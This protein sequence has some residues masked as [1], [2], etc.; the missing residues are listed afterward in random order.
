MFDAITGNAANVLQDCGRQDGLHPGN[1]VD[2]NGAAGPVAVGHCER[3]F[4]KGR[5]CHIVED[6][7][8]W[9]DREMFR[10]RHVASGRGHYRNTL[11]EAPTVLCTRKEIEFFGVDERR[12]I[13]EPG[14]ASTGRCP[15]D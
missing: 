6:D 9:S 15:A 13:S 8:H 11:T 1:A 10:A 3:K 4:L 2:R 14:Y 5:E 7:L 12:R